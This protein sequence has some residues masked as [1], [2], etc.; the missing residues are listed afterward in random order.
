MSLDQV[1]PDFN[2]ALQT[3]YPDFGPVRRLL[4]R[5]TGRLGTDLLRLRSRWFGGRVLTNERIVEYSVALRWMPESGRVLD[6]GCVSSRF[7]LQLASLGYEVWGIDVRPY[8]VTHR[9]FRFA[10]ADL[11]QW[12]TSER[13]DVI[14]AISTIE[15]FG[16][17]RWGDTQQVDAD[18]TLLE[19][20]ARLARPGGVLIASMP[21]GRPGVTALH[22][23]YDTASLER[24][25][26]G[27]LI[28]R[29]V[30]FRRSEH[31]WIPSS[32]DEAAAQPFE[33]LPVRAV[34]IL[35]AVLA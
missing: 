28:R 1:N 3:Y 34:V 19:R 14:T 9:N 2:D 24:L 10:K 27:F 33:E 15:H 32:L 25:F 4:F 23:V 22:R 31:D 11:F 17:G 16:I 29:K 26:D 7:P 21:F 35:E 5:L 20:L 18:R 13:F 6:L 12:E 30:F 8:P